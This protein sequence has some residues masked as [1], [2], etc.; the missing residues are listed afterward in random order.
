MT[1]PGPCASVP[2]DKLFSTAGQTT[3]QAHTNAITTFYT[4]KLPVD[5]T[6]TDTE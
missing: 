1:N 4:D 5:S 2:R 6:N 3:M